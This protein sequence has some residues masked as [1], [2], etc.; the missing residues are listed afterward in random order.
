MV[1][2]WES[3]HYSRAA[4]RSK[5]LDE[6]QRREGFLRN[7]RPHRPNLLSQTFALALLLPASQLSRCATRSAWK[8]RLNELNLLRIRYP[9]AQEG[10][11]SNGRCHSSFRRNRRDCETKIT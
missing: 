4:T 9:T 1:V 2:S 6:G 8:F 7:S 3:C 10:Q 11:F 5:T